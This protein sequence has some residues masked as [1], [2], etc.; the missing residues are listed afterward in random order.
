MW[1]W[2]Y[3]IISI[4]QRAAANKPLIVQTVQ[5]LKNACDGDLETC[6]KCA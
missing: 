6:T 3:L 1:P 4:Y 2:T 5:G